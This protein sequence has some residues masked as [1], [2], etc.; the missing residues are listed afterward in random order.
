MY[1][2]G[3]LHSEPAI[4]HVQRTA[5]DADAAPGL[6]KDGLEELDVFLDNRPYFSANALLARSTNLPDVS[7]KLIWPATE[8]HIK[9]YTAQ[10]RRVLSESPELYAS[11]VEPYIASF[12]A[13][14]TAW[15]RAIL[16]GEKEAERVLF[17]KPGDGG[18]MLLPDLKW[19]GTTLPALYLTAL[20]RDGSIRSMRDLTKAHLGLLRD[21]R[22]QAYAT[23]KEKYGVGAGELRLFVHYQPS[24]CERG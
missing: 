4:V 20:V 14:R 1:L 21:I 12:P 13:D 15:V 17:S 23:V 16:N 5:I 22:R 24:Y 19:D 6:V 3:T 10:P 9:K 18:F 11:I 2:L 7:L 8:T